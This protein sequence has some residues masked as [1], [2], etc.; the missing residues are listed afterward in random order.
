MKKFLFFLSF[1]LVSNYLFSTAFKE[2]FHEAIVG[3]ITGAIFEKNPELKTTANLH[4]LKYLAEQYWEISKNQVINAQ[5]VKNYFSSNTGEAFGLRNEQ[6]SH[7]INTFADIVEGWEHSFRGVLHRVFVKHA[8]SNELKEVAE[9]LNADVKTLFE[10]NSFDDV[11]KFLTE[12]ESGVFAKTLIRICN[13]LLAPA[14]QASQSRNSVMLGIGTL[15]ILGIVGIIGISMLRGE[16][17]GASVKK[18]V[19]EP[20]EN[21]W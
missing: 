4:F 16:G 19:Q 13:E 8:A 10:T 15:G 1:T 5:N 6:A 11:A 18:I 3:V 21:F 2:E 12:E 9:P 7:V 20:I 17:V 14:N